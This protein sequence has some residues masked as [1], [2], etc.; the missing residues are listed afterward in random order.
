MAES[1]AGRD[2][3]SR[4]RASRVAAVAPAKLS[5]PAMLAVIERGSMVKAGLKVDSVLK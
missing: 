1:T 3:K 5:R 2:L 4:N